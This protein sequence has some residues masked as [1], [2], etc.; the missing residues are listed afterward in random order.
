MVLYGFASMGSLYNF[1]SVNLNDARSVC[2]SQ[3]IDLDIL[4][5]MQIKSLTCLRLIG[6]ICIVYIDR[7]TLRLDKNSVTQ[8][9][10]LLFPPLAVKLLSLVL[11]FYLF[12]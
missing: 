8:V 9:V 5:L 12:G 10:S 11:Y 7:I 1:L 2:I 4:F 6:A 3:I